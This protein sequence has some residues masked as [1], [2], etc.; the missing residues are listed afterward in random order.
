MHS[1]NKNTGTCPGCGLAQ[2]FDN[3]VLCF[4]DGKSGWMLCKNEFCEGFV[5]P[6]T[7]AFRG[8]AGVPSGEFMKNFPP[9]NREPI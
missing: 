1:N 6:P 9:P 7:H 3:P 4:I 5:H 8:P 2:V